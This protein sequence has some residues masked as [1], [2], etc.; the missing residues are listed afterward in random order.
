MEEKKV[1]ICECGREFNNPQAF[2][3][4]KSHCKVHQMY[5]YGN[6]DFLIESDFIR[7]S[8]TQLTA[9][10]KAANK[11]AIKKSQL[12]NDI[13]KW[14]SE[15]HTCEKCGKVMTEKYGSGR[16]CCKSCANS[17]VKHGRYIN[18]ILQAKKHLS[19]KSTHKYQLEKYLSNIPKCVICG[20]SLE[21]KKRKNKT[22]CPE[23]KNILLSKLSKELV[24]K[25]G[26][27]L[28]PNPNKNCKAGTYKNIHY[29]SS[30][31]L[32][33]IIYH[34]DNFYEIVRNKEGF[35]YK[36][37]EKQRL[38]Y[39]DFIIDNVYYEIKNFHTDLVEAKIKQFPQ[40]KILRILYKED[41]QI[42]LNY[43][44]EKYGKEFWITAT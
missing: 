10:Q 24:S 17:H 30:W 1:Y 38:Y 21:Y 42:Y 8:K 31:E 7:H 2:N 13:E 28:N 15:K 33:F 41:I 43:C 23:C 4:H 18:N 35:P 32:A 3:G 16:F 20:K 36:Y 26:G 14:I 44:I 40:D 39:P 34:L 6:L 27:N 9:Q 12:D 11:T 25:R 29:D 19:I 37:K 5:K 22:C